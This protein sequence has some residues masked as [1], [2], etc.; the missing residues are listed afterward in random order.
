[1]PPL[2]QAHAAECSHA[3][4]CVQA[5]AQGAGQSSGCRQLQRTNRPSPFFNQNHLQV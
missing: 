3:E 1:M 2:T 4:A 5:G